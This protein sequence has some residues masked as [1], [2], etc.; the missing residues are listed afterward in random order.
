MSSDLDYIT[1]LEALQSIPFNV[2]KKLLSDVLRG[3]DK[4]ESVKKNF[5]NR[6][7]TFGTL[8]YE[9]H[10]INAIVDRLILNGL[11]K[12]VSLP[13]KS[14]WKVLELTPKGREEILNPTLHKKKL[15]N[16]VKHYETNI[17]DKDRTVFSALE[18]FLS[19]FND[20]QK[21]AI[22]SSNKHILCIAGAGSGKT[23]VLTKRIEFLTKYKSVNPSKVLAITFTRKA[24][25]EMMA[26]IGKFDPLGKIRVETFNS[27]CEKILQKHN[28]LVYG[29][30]VRVLA[31]RE[32]FSVIN[33]AL[34]SLNTNM[35]RA[36]ASYFTTQQRS[37]RS[38]E[39]L[40]SIFMND[41]FF[42]RDYFKFKNLP[43][44]SKLFEGA[45]YKNK[46][47]AELVYHVSKYIEEFMNEEGLRDFADQLLDTMNLFRVHPELIPKFEHIL[48]DEYQDVNSTQIEFVDMLNVS[49]VFAVGDPRQSIFGWRGSDI[50]YILGFEEKYEGCEVVSLVM[51]Y[52]STKAIVDLMNSAIK[53]LG[54]NDLESSFEGERELSLLKFSSEYSEFNHVVEEI[55][56]ST[57]PR[58]EIF[59]LARTNKQ[60]NELSNMLKNNLIDHVVKSDEMKSSI[61]AGANQVTLATI[62][63]IKGL[64]ADLVYVVGCNG[65]NFPCKGSEHPII[66]LVK[67]DEYDK[68]E[69]EKRLFYV[70]I[71]RARKKLCLSYSGTRA[72]MFITEEM[73]KMLKEENKVMTE[74]E[75][76]STKGLERRLK[77]W[78]LMKAKELGVPA[79]TIMHDKTIIDIRMK[80]P[81]SLRELEEV[82]GFGPTK[83]MRYGEEVLG[84]IIG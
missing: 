55:K 9:P 15:S 45:D 23:T 17:T 56:K 35:K 8:A 29:K 70:A 28:D 25:Q 48:I 51:N 40:A 33:K 6:L 38:D 21:K 71:S 7:D 12:S 50:K 4:N 43:L 16:H 83:I 3:D 77:D 32:K 75:E 1:V 60:L 18:S 52:R 65:S 5:L 27:F 47:S 80:L 74:D 11:I 44:S 2:G 31:Y 19:K 10:E 81:Q 13:G 62:H 64:E 49:N 39:Q 34:A 42:I 78:R 61:L 68:E 73:L 14:F 79:Y 22:I 58:K 84:L 82:Y 72:T 66:D 76:G 53:S 26:R 54:M 63:A 36:V 41:C 57:V 59:V 46:P 20:G 69:E 30:K 67:V 37:G 24:R